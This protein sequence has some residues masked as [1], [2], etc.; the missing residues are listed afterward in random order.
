MEAGRNLRILEAQYKVVGDADARHLY[1]LGQELGYAGRI[2]EAIAFLTKHVGRS[3]WDD[4]R[5]IACQRIA[6]HYTQRGEHEKAIEWAMK[7]MLI[8]EDWGEAYFI[9]AK[10]CY[11]L[12]IQEHA[13]RP[14]SPNEQRWWQ[15]CVHFAKTGL[16][17]PETSTQLF[18]NP[19]ERSFEIH[20]FL[21][22]ALSKTGDAK[23]ALESVRAA[24]T[25][26]PDDAQLTRNKE[27]Y[28]KFLALEEFKEK[29]ANLARVHGVTE[30]VR[31]FI[32]RAAQ[33]NRISHAVTSDH[34]R[35]GS[36]V[37]IGPG[38]LDIV[39]YVGTSFEAW[40]P[41]T[42]QKGGIGGSE[43]AVVEMAKRFVGKG[44]RV[45]V[46]GDCE[47]RG[48]GV[49]IEGTFDGVRY[50]H[51]T[52]FRDVDCD[53]LVSSRRPD[54]VDSASL[55][56]K[57]AIL[58]IHDIHCGDH[59]TANR[60]KK[61]DKILT[62]SE[63]HR[64]HVLEKY[65]FL[66]PA[67]VS[68]T[69]NGI[70]LGRFDKRVARDPHRAVYSSSLDRGLQCLLEVWP[71]V[72]R[73]VF[74]AELHIYY[75]MLNWELAAD[76]EG[77]KTIAHLK[78]LIE[79]LK[80]SGVTFHGRVPQG[81]L[82]IE[83]LK[84]GVWAYPTWFWETSCITAMEA[85]AAG[86]RMVTSPIA[87]LNET[88]GNRG[89]LVS[90]H[91]LSTEYKKKFVD[92]V[93]VAMEK[94]GEDDR[95]TLQTYARDHFGWDS[96]ATEWDAMLRSLAT[97]AIASPV[98]E[99]S[100]VAEM[101]HVQHVE[102]P[103]VQK[104]QIVHAVLSETATGG[105]V[106]NPHELDKTEITGGGCRPA[107]LLLVKELAKYGHTVRAFSTF[108]EAATVG[109]VEYLPLSQLDKRGRPNVM[110]AYYD[111]RVLT[112]RAGVFRIASHHTYHLFDA[113][114]FYV[115]VN[116]VPSQATLDVLKP[117]WAPWSDW[118]VLPNAVDDVPSW[119]PVPGRVVYHTSPDRGLHHLLR[120][121]PEIKRRVPH[122][123]LHVIGRGEKWSRET[124]RMFGMENSE[125]G[126]RARA[127]GEAFELA[128]RAGDV[129]SLTDLPR[130]L[131]MEQLRCAS[132]FAFPCSTIAP[133]ETFSVS[134][135]ECCK[136]GVPVVLSPV[137]ALES[138]YKDHVVMTRSPVEEHL[139][140][141]TDAVVS[142]LEDRQKA[143]H[144]SKLGRKLAAG[145]TYE[146]TGKVLNEI[147]SG[148]LPVKRT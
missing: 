52:S 95:V 112:G 84:S 92:E 128:R 72:R 65:P 51:H 102:I 132:V 13:L 23:G 16:S 146:R 67:K 57:S 64:G 22:M 12:A 4:E 37:A 99:S 116:T 147:V 133:C 53:V 36:D 71:E 135:M 58:W 81:R 129:V 119:D 9:A 45:R 18:L 47:L 143:E 110:W 90:G 26:V 109:G 122:A 111:T 66:D 40:N 101:A 3:G 19:L 87:A 17:K 55:R 44:H 77:K 10:A 98:A 145:Y 1:Y 63:W 113:Q 24:L 41:E 91:W 8:H 142:V 78:K 20:R 103:E 127:V 118:V 125:W 108:T 68:T 5:Y 54:A 59:L 14:H 107:F 144:F 69:R 93:V 29:L 104:G 121:W 100:P 97:P 74:D 70:D 76:A 2:D 106:M 39:I 7:G 83:M 138:I 61:F 126:R 117:F 136:I 148:R 56:Y 94:P 21:N 33:D 25:V 140:E 35:P 6:T 85:Q 130:P 62:L 80:D 28:E 105:V 31:N 139:S 49:S 15:R 60:A 43:T 30:D 114:L 75:G 134:A 46:Y 86:L 11:Y 115:D 38:G 141:F 34:A 88:V 73:R 82:A 124:A 123:S 27:V 131:L 137:D 32:E 42:I 79:D 96:L 48:S 50:L 89:A 120:A